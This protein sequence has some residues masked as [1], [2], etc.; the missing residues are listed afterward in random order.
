VLRSGARQVRAEFDAMEEPEGPRV[1][2]LEADGRK[3]LTAK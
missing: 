1:T 2:M 3:V